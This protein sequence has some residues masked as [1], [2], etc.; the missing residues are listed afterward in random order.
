[1]KTL[2]AEQISKITEQDSSIIIGLLEKPPSVEFGDYSFPCFSL[3]K[4]LKKSPLQIASE[5][6]ESLSSDSNL[7]SKVES[8]GGYVNFFIRPEVYARHVLL[9]HPKLGT[10]KPEIICIESPGPNTNKPL[11]L[12][13]LRNMLLG[14]SVRNILSNAGNKVYSVDIVNDRGVHICK[15]MLAYKLHGAGKTPE[16]EGRKGDFFV[17]DYYVDY[18]NMEKENPNVEKEIRKML[19][20]WES[21]DRETLELWI[22][23]KDWCLDGFKETY[24]NFGLKIDKAYYESEHYEKGREIIMKGVREGIFNKDEDGS[25]YADLSGVGMDKKVVLRADGTSIYITQDIYLAKQRF[26]DFKMD[27][28]VYVVASEQNHHFKALFEILRQLGYSFADKCYHLSYGMVNLPD[29]RM[30]SREGTV[31]D[32][33][34]F[35]QEVI[36]LAREELLKRYPELSSEEIEKRA[37]IIGMGAL[38]FFILKF[39]PA[40]DMVYNPKESV[41]FEGET[42]PY[43]QY[44]HARI[45]S[46]ERKASESDAEGPD[47]SA[48]NTIEDKKLLNLLEQEKACFID[49]VSNYKPSAITRYLLDLS[50][51][52]NEYYHKHPILKAESGVRD[53]RLKLFSKARETIA[54]NL[55][56]LE[57][58]APEEM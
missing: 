49:A 6:A 43:V 15:S 33:D 5:M 46:V 27:R 54:R 19:L 37:N 17:G 34:D 50:Q 35:R 10:E 1:M 57:I 42:G 28:M 13:H 55:A 7:F 21:R 58:Q 39:D 26:D 20:L 52:V 31:V 45:C 44:T 30:K 24:N 32:A 25:V 48:L 8:K 16:S 9:T 23:M 51:A 56:L 12:G 36:G 29:G 41:S 2:V 38:R 22:K 14:Q 53:A 18:A 3:A 4:E 40:K 11:H 47:Y